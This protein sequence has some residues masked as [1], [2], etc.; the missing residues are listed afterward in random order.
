MPLIQLAKFSRTLLRSK[1]REFDRERPGYAAAPVTKLVQLGENIADWSTTYAFKWC[2]RLG[3]QMHSDG[4]KSIDAVVKSMM[5]SAHEH[6][7]LGLAAYI[8]GFLAG[9]KP[10]DLVNDGA[11]VQLAQA[12]EILGGKKA[13]TQKRRMKIL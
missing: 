11:L 7:Q 9:V 8:Q 2:Y 10:T 12:A 5:E 4:A 13:P 3:A 1:T 6:W